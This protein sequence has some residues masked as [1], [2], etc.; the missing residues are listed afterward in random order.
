MIGALAAGNRVM[1]KLSEFTPATGRLLKDLL[2]R[3][4][5]DDMVTVVLGDAEVAVAF[6]SLPVDHLLFTGSTHVG[7]LVMRAAAEHLTPV[8]LELGANPRPLSRPT[9]RSRTPPSAS[10]GAKA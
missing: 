5:P 4:F 8:T 10:P 7:K 3:I 2:G 1:L 6:S 9:Y